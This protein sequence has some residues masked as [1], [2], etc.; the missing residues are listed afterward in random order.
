MADSWFD[1]ATLDRI[2]VNG[3]YCKEN[4]RWATR[5]QQA[6]NQRK[7]IHTEQTVEIIRELYQSG[8]KQVELAKMFNDSQGNI[9]NIINM[10]TWR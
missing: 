6:H 10:R 7:N 5:I 2:D 9:S 1:G 8:T 3:D 4:C